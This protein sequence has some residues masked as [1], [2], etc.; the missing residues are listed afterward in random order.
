M[1][2]REN[3]CVPIAVLIVNIAI[4]KITVFGML[5]DMNN[6][7]IFETCPNCATLVELNYDWMVGFYIGECPWCHK[8]M[9][10]E[11]PLDRLSE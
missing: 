7:T 4:W 11:K 3:I 5:W 2:Q 9:G 10:K 6:Q 8:Q 1:C